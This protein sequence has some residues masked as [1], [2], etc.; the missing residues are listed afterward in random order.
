MNWRLGR[1][2]AAGA[3]LAGIRCP[4]PPFPA[5]GAALDA[6]LAHAPGDTLA[7]GVDAV[8]GKAGADT[9]RTVGL[10]RAGER[11]PDRV[12]QPLLLAGPPRWPPLLPRVEPARKTRSAVHRRETG[13]RLAS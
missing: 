8:V 11:A 3:S 7:P 10:A 1:S 4:L 6:K 13:R 5:A 2:G 9:R 12:F